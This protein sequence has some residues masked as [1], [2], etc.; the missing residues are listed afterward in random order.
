MRYRS[1][2]CVIENYRRKIGFG[3]WGRAA[4]KAQRDKRK[5]RGRVCVMLRPHVLFP[6]FLLLFYI[7]KPISFLLLR[8]SSQNLFMSEKVAR[9]ALTI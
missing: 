9:M 8:S 5:R 4:C 3:Q 7:V 6:V 2:D 1:S